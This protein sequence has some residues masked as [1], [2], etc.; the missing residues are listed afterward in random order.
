[1]LF[2]EINK[3]Y[4]AGKQIV[5][6]DTQAAEAAGW[7][8]QSGEDTAALTRRENYPP[9]GSGLTWDLLGLFCTVC[10][11]ECFRYPM[12]LFP[13]ERFGNILMVGMRR[14]VTAGAVRREHSAYAT[15]VARCISRRPAFG[16]L[17]V[18]T[19]GPSSNGDA[20]GAVGTSAPR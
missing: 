8:S 13:G 1:M 11:C 14:F 9:A 15:A 6:D 3:Y 7:L 2:K 17:E 18:P 4:A 12:F 10:L 20:S 5:V 19:D 16:D